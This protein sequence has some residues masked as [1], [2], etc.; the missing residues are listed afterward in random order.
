MHWRPKK[1]VSARLAI[2]EGEGQQAAGRGVVV[3]STTYLAGEVQADGLDA[4]VLGTRSH[5]CDEL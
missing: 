3:E 2:S 1:K 5:V 4:D